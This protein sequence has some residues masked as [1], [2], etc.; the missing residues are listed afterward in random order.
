MVVCGTLVKEDCSVESK[1]RL[2]TVVKVTPVQLHK[3][4]QWKHE[5]DRWIS[6]NNKNGNHTPDMGMCHII[7]P[8][9][10]VSVK[11]Q[12]DPTKFSVHVFYDDSPQRSFYSYGSNGIEVV[13]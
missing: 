1:A 12:D 9:R 3:N 5:I 6:Y 11:W 8:G 2:G 13:K 10:V 4:S 7:R